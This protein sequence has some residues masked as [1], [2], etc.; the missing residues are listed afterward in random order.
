MERHLGVLED[1]PEYV[2]AQEQE[3][4]AAQGILR[5]FRTYEREGHLDVLRWE[6]NFTKLPQRHQKLL[7]R[8]KQAHESTKR[9]LRLNQEFLDQLVDAVDQE[10]NGPSTSGVEEKSTDKR[11][12]A[13]SSSGA[14]QVPAVDVEKVRYVLKDLVREWSAEGA[15][16]R[17]QSYDKVTKALCEL[18]PNR[19]PHHRPRVLV[20]GCG[21]GRLVLDLASNGF[22]CEGNEFSYFMLFTSAFVM[23]HSD[24]KDQFRV[25]PYCLG[26][27][28]NLSHHDQLRPI[29]IP[30]ACASDFADAITDPDQMSIVGG[31]FVEVYSRPEHEARW[32][33]VATCFFVDTAHNFV[34]YL[35]TVAHCLKP[36]G[37]W[38]NLGPLLW[39]WADSHT[40]LGP[41][42]LSCEVPLEEVHACARELGL[43]MQYKKMAKCNYTCNIK[44]MQQ[45]V[46]FCDFSVHKK[47]GVSGGTDE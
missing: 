6:K 4:R 41:N 26:S 27:C 33:A 35:E 17:S 30:D 15:V 19:G 31:D 22:C 8:V 5:A 10:N 44:S 12:S 25:F 24:A 28:N 16:E 21:L 18:F 45:T 1:H 36:G 9:C 40:Y 32:D 2:L 20:P 23:N 11:S 46:F 13:C 14:G 7:Q 42:E 37:Y 29:L 43:T 39:H 47:T 34:E 3:R 38:V